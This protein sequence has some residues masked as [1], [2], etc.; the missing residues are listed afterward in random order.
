M[1]MDGAVVV[2][3]LSEIYR[4]T[5]VR[6]AMCSRVLSPIA[7]AALVPLYPLA[8]NMLLND[9]LSV[10]VTVPRDILEKDRLQAQRDISHELHNSQLSFDKPVDLICEITDDDRYL[11]MEIT[12]DC[13]VSID[14]I[15]G[16]YDMYDDH[17]FSFAI[18]GNFSTKETEGTPKLVFSVDKPEDDKL[19]MIV[20]LDPRM[21][22]GA[23]EAVH[24][25][26]LM[27]AL[28]ETTGLEIKASKY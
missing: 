10:K 11:E 19:K 12:M 24:N 28:H 13:N 22:G 25:M 26:N 6:G 20:R 27:F 4:K 8:L 15:L 21:R 23:S 9:T 2:N 7:V 3:G 17:N 16:I 18:T 14:Q 5:L 1:D